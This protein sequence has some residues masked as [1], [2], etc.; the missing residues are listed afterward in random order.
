[1]DHVAAAVSFIQEAGI[2]QR[3]GVLRNGFY[4][5]VKRDSKLLNRVTLP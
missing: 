3:A 1:M 5:G 2:N 4:V